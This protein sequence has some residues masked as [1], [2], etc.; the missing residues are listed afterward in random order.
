MTIEPSITSRAFHALHEMRRSSSPADLDLI[1]GTAFASIG[2]EWFSLARFFKA[3]RTPTTSVVQGKFEPN[4][5]T[6]YVQENY[7]SAS[8]IARELLH[9]SEPYSWADVLGSRAEDGEQDRIFAEARE[10]GLRDGLFMPVRWT[11][12]SYAAVVTAGRHTQLSDP[13]NRMMAEVISAHYAHE[14]RRLVVPPNAVSAILSPRQRDCLSWVRHGKSSTDIADLLGI[15]A[16]TVEEHI[17]AASRKLG[18]R[19]RV[20][21]AVEASLLG[22]I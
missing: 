12:R 1:T 14:C 13:L 10:H 5:S 21:A 9:R 2:L 7:A 19:T 22:I 6:R 16:Q 17:A 15:S 20:Q 18:V 8:L 11:D 3:D 4:W